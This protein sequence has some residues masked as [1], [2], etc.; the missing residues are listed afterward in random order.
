MTGFATGVS[1]GRCREQ[2]VFRKP[3]PPPSAQIG[4]HNTGQ[5]ISFSEWSARTPCRRWAPTDVFS[6]RE[7][8]SAGPGT[9]RA[10]AIVNYN[11]GRIFLRD[12]RTRGCMAAPS[13]T[14]DTRFCRRPSASAARTS[15]QPGTFDQ[16]ISLHRGDDRVPSPPASLR[17]PFLRNRNCPG[18][19]PRP[20]WSFS[21]RA[22]DPEGRGDYAD[23]I[24]RAV[25]SG[26]TTVFLPCHYQLTASSCCGGR[27]VVFSASAAS[28]TTASTTGPISASRRRRITDLHRAFR[29]PARWNR[30]GFF[31]NRGFL[32]AS[33]S[34]PCTTP[35]AAEPRAA[36]FP[37][38]RCRERIPVPPP[39][40]PGAAVEH[41]ERRHPPHQRRRRSLDPRIQDRAGRHTSFTPLAAAAPRSS[42][43]SATRPRRERSRR[44]SSTRTPRSGLVRRDLFTTGIPSPPWSA[45]SATTKSARSS[46]AREASSPI[47]D[48][49]SR[50]LRDGRPR[51]ENRWLA[52]SFT[53][54]VDSTGK[55]PGDVPGDDVNGVL[56]GRNRISRRTGSL[57]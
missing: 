42:E 5:S 16:R 48:G 40:C 1:T 8:I 9:V 51:I 36:S 4:F 33:G 25:D 47:A 31:T 49:V 24:Q 44:C 39:T 13:P 15:R 27:S 53:W 45:R 18:A 17:L 50:R 30:T 56:S 7:R 28:S 29:R 22:D 52:R 26:A 6:S 20:G 43:D 11:R 55:P 38:G 54:F 12:I 32:E 46:R 19:P 2:P 57:M 3:Y 41:R 10:P 35:P 21:N 34:M 37:R 23:E 14:R